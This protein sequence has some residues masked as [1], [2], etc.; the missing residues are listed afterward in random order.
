MPINHSFHHNS[1]RQEIVVDGFLHFNNGYTVVYSLSALST[2]RLFL[3]VMG[4]EPNC[5]LFPI[6][7]TPTIRG[8]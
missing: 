3:L 6:G 1:I 4:R 8:K 5:P 7:T 2:E